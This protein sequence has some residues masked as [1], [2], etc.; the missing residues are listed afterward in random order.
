LKAD[1]NREAFDVSC[2]EKAIEKELCT[3]PPKVFFY[4]L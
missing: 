3:A 4:D 2:E 1:Y